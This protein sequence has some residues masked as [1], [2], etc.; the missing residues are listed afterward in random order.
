MTLVILNL[1]QDL[2]IK[3][4]TPTIRGS[5]IFLEFIYFFFYSLP[6]LSM[7]EYLIIAILA[8][9]GIF[10]AAYLTYETLQIFATQANGGILGAL[11]CDINST[12]S[13]SG[14][15]Q[16]PRAIIFSVGDFKVAF[17]MIALVVYPI[18]F[19]LALVGWFTKKPCPAKVLTALAF[20]GICFNGYVISQEIIV[21]VFCPL[22]AMCTVIIIAIFFLSI[23]IWKG[24]KKAKTRKS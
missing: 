24:E 21:G 6:F 18:L 8:A 22:C 20:G 1:F 9:I 15:L 11:P 17:P 2:S 14:I 7:K 12:L 10:N 4:Q 19:L 23:S 5:F 13:C 3:A 16:N